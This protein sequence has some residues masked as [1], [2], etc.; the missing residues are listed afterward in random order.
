LWS[1]EVG[2]GSTVTTPTTA[3]APTALRKALRTATVGALAAVPLL[4]ASPAFAVHR[5]AGDDPGPGLSAVATILTYIGI[6]LAVFVVI[7]LLVMAPGM[8]KGNR[9]RPHTLS[10]WAAPVWFGGPRD[11]L[12]NPGDRALTGNSLKAL[13]AVIVSDQTEGGASARW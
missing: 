4:L 12:G 6:P 1:R 8:A 10:W 13:P 5:E 9:Y 2:Y 7:S 11:E 3:T